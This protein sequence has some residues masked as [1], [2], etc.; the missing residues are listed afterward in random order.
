MEKIL[1]M[2][3]KKPED[4]V[5]EYRRISVSRSHRMRLMIVCPK[6]RHK[7]AAPGVLWLHGG[8]YMLGFPEMV[9]MS[10]AIDLVTKC[11]AVVVSPAYRLSVLHPYPAALEDCYAALLY[12]KKHARELGIRQN[13]IMVGGESAGGGLTAALC[14]YAKD[15]KAVDIAFQMPL[16][17]MLSCED[18]ASSKDNHAKVW[19]TRKN[20]LGWRLYLRRLKGKN[21]PS[22]ASPARRKDYSGLPPA[23]TFVGDIEPFY[24]ETLDYIKNLQKAGV[25]AEVDIYPGFYHAYDMLE[26]EK[27]DT[28][29]AAERFIKKFQEASEKYFSE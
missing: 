19:N 5:V 17:P 2:N 20:H 24:Q 10:R 3:F 15:K 21:I 29:Q 8:G 14:M 22:Y 9:Y 11:G 18:T 27:A 7:E 28:Q 16:Y 26:P 6:N 12:I 13:Q 25:E 1:M 23:Y 4:C